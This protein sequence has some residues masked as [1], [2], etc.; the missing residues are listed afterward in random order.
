MF[1]NSKFILFI[2]KRKSYSHTMKWL[3]QQTKPFIP[4]LALLLLLDLAATGIGI[5]MTLI[6]R[7]IIDAATAGTSYKNNVFLYVSV[8]VISLAV[9]AVTT[10]LTSVINENFSFNIRLRTYNTIMNSYWQDISRYHSGDVITRLSSDVDIAANGIAEI[11]PSIFSLASR[12]IMAFITL[13]CFDWGIA[14]F[15]LILAPITAFIGIISGRSMGP[16]QAK[17]QQSE[18]AYKSYMQES[19]SNLTVFKAFGAQNQAGE[20]LK[21]LRTQRF[22]WVMKRQKVSAVSSTMLAL[23]FQAGYIS[24][25]VY[26]AQQLSANII[27]YGTMSVFISLVGQIQ[28][29]VLGLSKVIPRVV[30]IFT[31][32][33]RIIELDAIPPE[34]MSVPEFKTA[35]LG[36]R[37]S[38]VSFTYERDEIFKDACLCINPGEFVAIMGSSGIGKTTFVR[39]AMAYIAPDSGCISLFDRTGTEHMVTAGARKYISYVPQGNTLISGRIIDNIRLGA[40]EISES[41]IW[42]I[43]KVVAVDD[44]VRSTPELLNTV[45]GE[46]GLGLSEG[47]AQRLALARALAAKA[48]VL[49]LDES[50]SALDEETELSVLRHLHAHKKGITCLL[51]SHRRS[52]L[53][54]CDRCVKVSDKHFAEDG[55]ELYSL[56]TN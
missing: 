36:L 30:S 38:D 41:E 10:I 55:E 12:L 5:G 52:V 18:S 46:R 43:L 42:E 3:K 45:I 9:S 2:K 8:I 44:F 15:A 29:P 17:V 21:K 34:D 13:A 37:V 6:S 4:S 22:E 19:I 23:A 26:S 39:L 50:T 49:I 28:S 25:F 35:E 31:S 32:A 14:A 7:S 51:I 24:A 1:K 20:T 33:Q 40:P 16:I 11:L 53:E 27:T 56:P 47:Q 54:F 48:S